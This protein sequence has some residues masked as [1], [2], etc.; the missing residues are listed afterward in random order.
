MFEIDVETVERL[1]TLAKRWKAA[2][3][4][5]GEALKRL[6]TLAGA[7]FESSSSTSYHEKVVEKVKSICPSDDMLQ[8]LARRGKY[9]KAGVDAEAMDAACNVLRASVEEMESICD[10]MRDTFLTWTKSFKENGRKE[11]TPL[12]LCDANNSVNADGNGDD[13]VENDKE[14]TRIRSRNQREGRT[15]MRGRSREPRGR[16][17]R[18][19]TMND[20]KTKDAAAAADVSKEEG[21]A[22]S[23]KIATA[24]EAQVR[25]DEDERSE[26]K[27]E[28]H[29]ISHVPPEALFVRFSLSKNAPN[30]S[31]RT[32]EQWL[33]LSESACEGAHKELRVKQIV[34]EKALDALRR[35]AE[36]NENENDADDLFFDALIDAWDLQVFLDD[37][38]FDALCDAIV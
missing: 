28:L 36:K 25:Q 8:C 19:G 16:R 1:A 14:E 31:F 34:G 15:M 38:A 21:D 4:A 12:I 22:S 7:L 9:A 17:E 18:S 3:D 5:G 6:K 13:M 11:A 33:F 37:G 24:E 35:N 10:E 26:E 32:F 2:S 20:G 29:W 30:P 23:K 27:K